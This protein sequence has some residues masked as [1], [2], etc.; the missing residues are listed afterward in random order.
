MKALF[1]LAKIFY[2]P[3]SKEQV[4][5]WEYTRTGLDTEVEIVY[6]SIFESWCYQMQHTDRWADCCMEID[7]WQ[8]EFTLVIT[9]NQTMM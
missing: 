9:E 8:S 1:I 5:F 2:T 6:G 4:K 3:R 7:L